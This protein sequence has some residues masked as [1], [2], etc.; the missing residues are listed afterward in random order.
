M[1]FRE[2]LLNITSP[3]AD[4][5]ITAIRE[6]YHNA[7]PGNIF[8]LFFMFNVQGVSESLRFQ[9]NV[10]PNMRLQDLPDLCNFLVIVSHYLFPIS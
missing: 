5:I 3:H 6:G 2:F 4:D 1:T 7:F 9:L 10:E 8:L